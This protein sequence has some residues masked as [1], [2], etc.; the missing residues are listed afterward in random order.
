[1][2]QDKLIEKHK[3]SLIPLKLMPVKLLKIYS[4]DP[5]FNGYTKYHH[6]PTI[7]SEACCSI[8]VM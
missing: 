2:L 1:M 6:F 7:Y 4:M 5:L 3:V 8:H